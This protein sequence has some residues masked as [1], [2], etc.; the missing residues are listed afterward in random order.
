MTRNRMAQMAQK[1]MEYDMIG[2]HTE[3]PEFP[4][5]RIRLLH[6]VLSHQD[7]SAKLKDL[8]AIVAS[9]AQMGLDT[10]DL[11]G[12]ESAAGRGG[13]LVMRARQLKVLAGDYF[14][15]RFYHLLAQAGQVEM[16]RRIG[17][18]ICELNRIKIGFYTKMR[19]MKLNAEEYL[20]HGAELK[21]GLFL[22]FGH[23]MTGLYER[24]WPE[25][26]DR[27]SRCELLLQELTRLE[28]PGELGGSWGFW[29]VLNEGSD[30]DRLAL[31]DKRHDAGFVRQL[32]DKYSV[33]DK[34]SGMLS[35]TAAQLQGLM[36][37]IPS[38]KLV[39]ELKPL[40]APFLKAAGP[41]PAKVAT[42]LG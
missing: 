12:N 21:S 4:E 19:Q 17:D 24:L 29:H 18:A 26:V 22:S 27:Y 5:G 13:L 10:H 2:L 11:V 42:E 9:L 32:F 7:E 3:L 25:I 1:Y 41:M 35:Q 38:D 36:E 15:G 31:A 37:R 6:A 40:I 33:S 28:K 30:E 14:S 8:M 23:L 16:I 20:L 39:Q 34:L